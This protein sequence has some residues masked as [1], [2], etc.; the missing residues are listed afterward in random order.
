MLFYKCSSYKNGR[1]RVEMEKEVDPGI[2]VDPKRNKILFNGKDSFKSFSACE[3]SI[4]SS[5]S[6]NIIIPSITIN[7]IE[8][9]LEI[10]PQS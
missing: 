5:S 9:L 8:T 1:I 3:I 4:V 10:Q 7:N 2:P 6:P